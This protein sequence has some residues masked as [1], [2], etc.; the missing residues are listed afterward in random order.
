M[1]TELTECQQALVDKLTDAFATEETERKHSAF[2]DVIRE[3]QASV[4]SGYPPTL[5]EW[6]R[7]TFDDG[8]L[9]DMVEHGMDA[10]WFELTYY[11]DTSNL[12]RLYEED[13]WEVAGESVPYIVAQHDVY[14]ASQF[15][16]YMIWEACAHLAWELV[17]EAD[18]DDE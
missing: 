14:S 15:E 18:E 3:L 6:L 4:D 9:H 2:R 11:D 12:Y 10:G 16:C 1:V 5:K 13:V 7:Q 8:E 17:D